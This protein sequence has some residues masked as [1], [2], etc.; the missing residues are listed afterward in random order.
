M[1][2][3]LTKQICIVIFINH[4]CLVNNHIKHKCLIASVFQKIMKTKHKCIVTISMFTFI[5]KSTLKTR[6]EIGWGYVYIYNLFTF[7]PYRYS[8]STLLTR[9]KIHSDTILPPKNH[10]HSIRYTSSDKT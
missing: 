3:L 4:K 7:S 5:T 1:H 8:S 2:E 9:N 6:L 10:A